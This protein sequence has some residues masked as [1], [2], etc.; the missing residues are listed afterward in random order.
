MTRSD[1]PS[2]TPLR[3]SRTNGERS[4]PGSESPSPTDR[5]ALGRDDPP[6]AWSRQV[7]SDAKRAYDREAKRRQRER[8][9]NAPAPMFFDDTP[10]PGRLRSG[11][12]EHKPPRR[13]EPT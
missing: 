10:E 9:R 6:R 7:Q 11:L 8:S 2:R 12:I 5:L 3:A 1:D 13:E 4:G